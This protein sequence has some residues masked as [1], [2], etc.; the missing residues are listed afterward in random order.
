NSS[1]QWEATRQWDVGLDFGLF[2]G[3]LTGSFNYYRKYTDGM[4]YEPPYI[5]AIGEGGYQWINAA[6]MTNTGIE[7]L[8][9]YNGR[10]GSDF[11]YTIS[12]NV[13]TNNNKIE[14][15]PE[16]V[17]YTYGGNGLGENILGRPLHSF[18]GFV[19]EGL[20]ETKEEVANSPEQAG[21]GLGRI[22]YKD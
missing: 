21:K 9:T 22:R 1:L 18:Y 5:A 10:V 16:S 14:D 15:L 19:A 13:S 6:N 3:T 12:G 8:L 11:S 20:F 4:L 7:L 17:K 2:D